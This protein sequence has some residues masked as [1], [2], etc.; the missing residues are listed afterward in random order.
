MRDFI[1][2]EELYSDDEFEVVRIMEFLKDD[3]AGEQVMQAMVRWMRGIFK[4]VYF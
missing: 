4:F 2:N 1:E 3:G